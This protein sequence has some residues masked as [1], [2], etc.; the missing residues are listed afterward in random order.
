MIDYDSVGRKINMIRK[1][2]G[3]TEEKLAEMMDVQQYQISLLVN[4]KKGSGIDN[5]QKL[6]NTC[7]CLNINLQDL[8]FMEECEFMKKYQ[9]TESDDLVTPNDE[10]VAE[11]MEKAKEER[12][13]KA[14]LSCKIKEIENTTE[15]I[16]IEKCINRFMDFG[17]VCGLELGYSYNYKTETDDLIIV[18]RESYREQLEHLNN[19]KYALSDG[20]KEYVEKIQGLVAEEQ[21]ELKM[22]MDSEWIEDEFDYCTD[23]YCILDQTDL[24]YI[25]MYL[26]EQKLDA[27]NYF[28]AEIPWYSE[29]FSE[30]SLIFETMPES[31]LKK[32][33]EIYYNKNNH[34]CEPCYSY[35]KNTKDEYGL[36]SDST[37]SLS[38]AFNKS[39]YYDKETEK[40]A[41]WAHNRGIYAEKITEIEMKEI[42][43]DYILYMENNE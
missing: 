7:Q 34:V 29:N 22:L 40:I 12:K 23:H 27:E 37:D 32:T 41:D 3:I 24:A 9:I 25:K 28:L 31:G 18:V 30:S 6:Y 19:S 16:N 43:K 4:A 11:E 26:Y 35:I 42:R 13:K 5:L 15:F 1:L 2:R 8:L 39:I 20:L 36:W 21:K 10:D 17:H 38:E 14:E 33:F